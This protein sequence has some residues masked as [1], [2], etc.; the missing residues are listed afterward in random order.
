MSHVAHLNLLT[1]LTVVQMD[2]IMLVVLASAAT[3]A[4]C[5]IHFRGPKRPLPPGKRIVVTDS[6]RVLIVTGRTA[7][8]VQI[9]G[10]AVENVCQMV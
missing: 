2:V 1:P 5:I 4:W 7:P 3:A 6:A 8:V 10:Q 9:L